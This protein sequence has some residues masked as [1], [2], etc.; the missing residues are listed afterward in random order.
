[1]N[2]RRKLEVVK[3]TAAELAAG[4]STFPLGFFIFETDTSVIKWAKD[5][6][7]PYNSLPDI[8][9]GLFLTAAERAKILLLSGTNT[10]DETT[11]GILGK[12]GDGT[13]IS[14]AYLP[15]YVDDVLEYTN[16]ATFPV[17]GESSKIYIDLAT[18]KQY[19]WGGSAY[20]NLT[21]SPG[22]TDAVP[23]GA[24]NKYF[25]NARAIASV[26]TGYAKAAVSAAIA[27][28]DSILVAFGKVE[29][30]LEILEARNTDSIT[31]G[32]TNKYWTNART[33]AAVLTGFVTAAASATITAATPILTAFG[34]IQKRLE[35]LEA[36]EDLASNFNPLQ[37]YQYDSGGAVM[38]LGIKRE[39][40]LMEYLKSLGL[41]YKGETLI[42]TYEECVA[43]ALNS[44]TTRYS[45]LKIDA[46][47]V[48]TELG[49]CMRTAAVFTNTAN[50]KIFLYKIDLATK[51]ATLVAQTADTPGLFNA[52]GMRR[53]A[54]TAPYSA[55]SGYYMMGIRYETTDQ[56]TPGTILTKVLDGSTMALI[57]GTIRIS[58]TKN[59]L[60]PATIDLTTSQ[61]DA[62]SASTWGFW[63]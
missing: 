8:S 60:A 62:S 19:R 47:S 1:M 26:L 46:D 44:G 20:V 57:D 3:G 12:I 34:I 54:L 39:S 7:T 55:A 18:D 56:T 51:I 10:G 43:N 40:R 27:A 38:K 61:I 45:L 21:A 30:R 2:A 63:N 23:E 58:G 50:N 59:T 24:T 14:A 35:L 28:G 6:N 5:G 36:G 53:A 37:T 22:T 29:K 15:S 32:A 33:I 49:V 48:I 9:A 17:T 25:T 52:T 31:E 16:L 42:G 41:S 11:A 13:K 4:N